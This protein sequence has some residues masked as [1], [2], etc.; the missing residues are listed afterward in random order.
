MFGEIPGFPFKQFIQDCQVVVRP[1]RE[2]TG[3]IVK[4]KAHF[5]QNILLEHDQSTPKYGEI[6]DEDILDGEDTDDES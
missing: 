3:V 6:P 1:L 4:S 2:Y 5:V